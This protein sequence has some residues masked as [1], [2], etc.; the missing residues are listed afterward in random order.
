MSLE[1]A[2]LHV[3]GLDFAGLVLPVVSV[4]ALAAFARGMLGFGNAL[5]A[6]PLL[7]LAVR[8]QIASPVVALANL[9]GI[10]VILV[11]CWR[12]V[13]F[14]AAWRLI[15]GCVIGI[16]VGLYFI[17][18]ANESLVRVV[19]GVILIVF[20][21]YYLI[22][23]RLPYLRGEGTSYAFGL[24]S[25][26]LG[27]AYNSNGPP[28]VIYGALRRWPPESF[29]ATLQGVFLPTNAM[30]IV[31]HAVAGLTTPTVLKLYGYSLPFM[32]GATLLGMYL[33]RRIPTGQ[34]SRIVYGFLVV[35]GVLLIV[36][37]F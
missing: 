37:A 8:V 1:L 22:S 33:G 29:R 6:M 9:T 34:F 19:L 10:L 7:A 12:S 14:G 5:I 30:V 26:I 36:R 32:V 21:L 23:P 27:A 13:D 2:G 20:G 25:G 18:S 4:L 31:A 35:M 11:G 15:L 24:A 17:K 3:A 28:I 16:P